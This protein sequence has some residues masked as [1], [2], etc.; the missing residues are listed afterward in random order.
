MKYCIVNAD[1]FGA[2]AAVNRGI[3]EAHRNGI[4][5]SAS[6]M[7]DR[8]GAPEAAALASALPHLSVGLHAELARAHAT[9]AAARNALTAQWRLFEALMGAPPTHL[10][11]HHNAH[12]DTLLA[13]LFVDLA[14]EKG[15]PLRENGEVRYFSNFYGRWGGES[16]AE[17][18]SVESLLSI[19]E[20]ELRD[21][22]TELACHP[23]YA[24]ED[25][26]SDYVVERE[27]ELATLCSSRVARK[28]ASLG[29]RL[30]SYRDYAILQ[31]CAAGAG[32]Q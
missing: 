26:R 15:V 9:A 21:G 7:V 30:I 12:R 13:P 25:L 6:L 18:I 29:V 8:P 3:V 32:R 24:S 5:T 19:I 23:G 11:A 4:V 20:R 22:F 31:G 28:L 10:D 2:T 1:D 14:R 17:Q 16:H 27:I